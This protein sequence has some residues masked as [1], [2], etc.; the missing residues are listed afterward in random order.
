MRK[1]LILFLA[2]ALFTSCGKEDDPVIDKNQDPTEEKQPEGYYFVGTPNNEALEY[3]KV[4]Y[5]EYKFFPK[6]NV[7]ASDANW[8]PIEFKGDLPVY[9]DTKFI[10]NNEGKLTE[11]KITRNISFMFTYEDSYMEGKAIGEEFEW[12]IRIDNNYNTLHMYSKEKLT[13]NIS[14]A[15]TQYNTDN[16]IVQEDWWQDGIKVET[17]YIEYKANGNTLK[18]IDEYGKTRRWYEYNSDNILIWTC[19]ISANHT[20]NPDNDYYNLQWYDENDKIIR[21]EHRN[22]SDS[23]LF[24]FKFIE[25]TESG[26]EQHSA[27]SIYKDFAINTPEPTIYRFN[28]DTILNSYEEYGQAG[29]KIKVVNVTFGGNSEN[30]LTLYYFI[31]TMKEYDSDGKEIALIRFNGDYRFNLVKYRYGDYTYSDIHGK[32]MQYYEYDSNNINVYR[33]TYEYVYNES[34]K[35]Y[36]YF[37]F[38][39]FDAQTNV[40]LWYRDQYGVKR[41][42]D[43]T[44]FGSGKA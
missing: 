37:Q 19:Y 24:Y 8:H 5:A 4:I 2:I 22:I 25:K 17:T 38:N 18:T 26:I 14:G 30:D 13:N 35:E 29:N 39:C 16:K 23:S 43:G 11:Y 21:E 40:F 9:S 6:K 7:V 10:F 20:E 12:H 3:V 1:I 44:P 15:I 33:Y 27:Y 41:N 28:G 42:P 31:Q 36:D 32:L 34:T